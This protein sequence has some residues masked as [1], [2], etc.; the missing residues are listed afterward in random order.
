MQLMN[1]DMQFCTERCKTRHFLSPLI[2]RTLLS[3]TSALHGPF[4][5]EHEFPD[6]EIR[7][8]KFATGDRAWRWSAVA[9]RGVVDRLQRTVH[10]QGSSAVPDRY[11]ARHRNDYLVRED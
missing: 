1:F 7:K 5:D 6:R 2:G 4:E 8:S 9:D 3:R 10:Q 11:V